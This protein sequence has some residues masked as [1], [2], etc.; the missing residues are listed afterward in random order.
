MTE[1]K[2]SFSEGR[3]DEAYAMVTR[4]GEE[5]PLR[6]GKD[7]QGIV[8]RYTDAH[9]KAARANLRKNPDLAEAE[10]TRVL[11]VEG[12]SEAKKRQ[13]L[14]IAH[15]VEARRRAALNPVAK[16][17]TKTAKKS[18]AKSSIA[19]ASSSSKKTPKNSGSSRTGG[20]DAARNCLRHGDN[21]CVI[22]ALK[23]GRAKSPASLALLIETYRTIGDN[24]SARQV[25][26][27]FVRRYPN[28]RRADRYQQMMGGQ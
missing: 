21:Q 2:R 3:I 10:A 1:A 5:S 4:I 17:K 26:G 9:L 18:T 15:R 24:S 12:I 16:A 14:K 19:K 11:A 25:M 8:S 22:R 7:Y 20:L 6:N 13:A 27:T 23:N 28:D